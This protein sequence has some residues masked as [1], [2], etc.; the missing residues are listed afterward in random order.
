MTER[1]TGASAAPPMGFPPLV[2]IDDR[3]FWD[4]VNAGTLL[5]QRCSDCTELRHPPGPM[6][7]RCGSLRWDAQRACGRGVVHSWVIPRHPLMPGFHD[8]Y[9]VVLVE[10]EEGAR[11]VSLLVGVSPS[12]VRN[13]MAVEVCFEEIADGVRLHRFR[14]RNEGGR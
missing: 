11:L 12:E 4:G 10:L 1:Q 8:P 9:I 2:G 14:P 6:C 13:D 3:F 7:P 5:L